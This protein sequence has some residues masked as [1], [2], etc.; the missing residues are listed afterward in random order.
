MMIPNVMDF[1]NPPPSADEYIQTLR[2]DVGVGQDEY[3]LLQPTRVVQRKGIEHAIELV[4]RLGVK[5][6]LVIS[7]A[8]GDEGHEYER[9]LES[10]ADLLDAPTSFISDIIREAR[11]VTLDGRKVYTL[12]DAYHSA[13]VV[14]YPSSL[15]GFGNAFLEAIYFCKP[16]VVNNYSIFAI[17]IKPKGFK[18][19]EFDGFITDQTVNQVRLVLENP[20]LA[21]EDAENNYFLA[22]KHYSYSMLERRLQTLLKEHFGENSY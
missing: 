20:A 19:I 15:E 18:V 17:D 16:I 6:H 13:D 8:S 5:A 21:Q 10:F 9:R 22:K 4:H 2:A 3:F 7:H 14:T 12:W 11:G 1:D